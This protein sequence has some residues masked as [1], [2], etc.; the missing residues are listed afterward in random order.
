[1]TISPRS[2]FI[3]LTLSTP[4]VAAACGSGGLGSYD[5]GL[6]LEKMSDEDAT[7]Y[8]KELEAHTESKV[9]T[10]NA[11]CAA[12]ASIGA[13]SA[14]TV[15]ELRTACQKIYDSCIASPDQPSST[16]SCRSFPDAAKT[17]QGLTVAELNACTDEA[18]AGLKPLADPKFCSLLELGSSPT[19]PSSP[20]CDVVKTKCPALQP[21][22]P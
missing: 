11:S 16:D 18:I 13:A 21:M 8:C 9:S 6:Q 10:K 5:G 20:K 14:M 22:K 15:A 12:L 7:Q 19:L 2:T 4:L 1:M 17:C 3:G